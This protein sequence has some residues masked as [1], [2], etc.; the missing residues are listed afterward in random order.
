MGEEAFLG[1]MERGI[2]V[3][4]Q[5]LAPLLLIS[6]LVG[7][8]VGLFQTVTQINEMTLTF[9]PKLV[10]VGLVLLMLGPWMLNVIMD[11]STEL[12]LNIPELIRT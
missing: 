9:I 2:W 12:I 11:F 8:M 10:V 5:I 7:L 3:T 4:A 6:S 1:V